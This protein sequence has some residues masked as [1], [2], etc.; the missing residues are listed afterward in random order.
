MRKAIGFLV[1]ATVVVG[2][3]ATPNTLKEEDIEGIKKMA[4]VTSLADEELKILDH[5]H[6]E[7]SYT[8]YQSGALGAL[9]EVLVES[10]YAAVTVKSALGGDPDPLRQ[11]AA[12]FPVKEVFDD[13]F[14]RM[15]SVSWEVIDPQDVEA[16]GID[17]YP[18][19]KSATG[20][21]I[22]DYTALRKKLNVDT[23][24]EI[25]FVHGLAVCAGVKRPTAVIT[26][27][28]SVIDVEKNRLL[29]RKTISSDDYYINGYIVDE[30]AAD[31][32]ELYKNEIVEAIRA[33]THLLV[34]ELGG[35][36]TESL[37]DKSYWGPNK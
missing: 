24:L 12:D 23:V 32:A 30:F 6:I 17:K 33:F 4:V 14:F 28:V 26:A 34:S 7:E 19:H 10:A 13:N 18:T 8:N 31:K 16:L 1:I 9:A 21:T 22:H 27:D 15:F 29:M 5:T 35:D 2:C 20:K 25:S 3:A 11:A 36:T 37:K